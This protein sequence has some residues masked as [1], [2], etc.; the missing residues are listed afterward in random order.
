MKKK[1]NALIP[2]A[3]ILILLCGAYGLLTWQQQKMDAKKAE[4][5]D[6]DKIY[7]TDIKGLSSIT[8]E[9]DG[10]G[11]SFEKE[12]DTWYYKTDK[13]C[14]IRQ[15][16]ISTLADSL[17]R[18]RAER[19]LDTPDS[20]ASYGLDTPSVQYDT[21]SQDGTSKTILIGSQVAGTG[22][23]S[24]G[25][26]NGA[27]EYYACLKG[28]TQV[29]TIGS[30]LTD[31]AG[32]DLYNFVETETLP[33]VTNAD[34]KEITVT[35]GGKTSHFYKKTVDSDNNIAWYKDSPDNEANRLSDNGALNNL[36]QAISGLSIASCTTY[37]A[38]DEEL[39]SYG[40]ST[41]AMT[42]SWT[43]AKGDDTGSVTL[44]IGSPSEDGSG[45]YTRKDDSRAINLISKESV[46]KCLN[47]DYPQ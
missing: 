40:L 44:S 37:K 19:S 28:G 8:W 2:A 31:T 1:K 35:K 14:P 24:P 17:S 3:A 34:I 15:S 27:A 4:N 41:P 43:Y 6:A 47:A 33:Y 20:L 5:K 16:D 36:A 45:Y 38:S 29:Y 18:L 23:T 11:L 9:K 42:L 21:V 46:E 7:M 22:D 12:G 26:A 13:D 30:Y 32:K 25:S 10:K 39:G